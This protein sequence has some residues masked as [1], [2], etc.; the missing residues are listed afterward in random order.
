MEV[1]PNCESEVSKK[2]L[3]CKF[4][5]KYFCSMTCLMQHSSFHS[6]TTGANT[7][8]TSSL[9][10]KQTKDQ[11][12]IHTNLKTKLQKLSSNYQ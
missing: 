5:D 8:I 7:L 11:D 10:K 12:H 4:C 6:K 2:V 3:T 1:C 9:K